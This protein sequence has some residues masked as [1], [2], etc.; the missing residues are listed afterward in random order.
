[1]SSLRSSPISTASTSDVAISAAYVS[2]HLINSGPDCSSPST[3]RAIVKAAFES[4]IE[5]I[6][7]KHI[8]SLMNESISKDVIKSHL[9]KFRL[10]KALSIDFYMTSYD[11]IL[12]HLAANPHLRANVLA[13]S[14]SKAIEEP[15]CQVANASN[16]FLS[17]EK[18]PG[19]FTNEASG[20]LNF[21]L[22]SVKEAYH[23]MGE[24]LCIDA[25]MDLPLAPPDASDLELFP[26]A[27]GSSRAS[28]SRASS[29][30]CSSNM[31][32]EYEELRL[33]HQR[34]V[35][36]C[37][38]S[39]A[40]QSI[41]SSLSKLME[42][43]SLSTDSLKTRDGEIELLMLVQSIRRFLWWVTV[44][45]GEGSMQPI[46]N[47]GKGDTYRYDILSHE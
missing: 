11:S 29:M 35:N 30:L 24:A 20:L 17:L 13:H 15:V 34:Q 42:V 1:M 23:V 10:K 14:A 4:G 8:W 7:P 18:D 36:Q 5:S 27:G 2:N 44:Q 32:A 25:A 6:S 9:Q 40:Q 43:L 19:A 38:I 33:Q 3:L 12:V 21:E 22:P 37:C 46:G 45:S 41:L 31:F 26:S 16:H 28:S 39:N 47:G